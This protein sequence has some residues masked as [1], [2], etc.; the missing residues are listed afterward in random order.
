MSS[1]NDL[2]NNLVTLIQAG[3]DLA[4]SIQRDLEQDG[5]VSDESI[6]TLNSFYLIYE[7][8]EDILDIVN[9]IN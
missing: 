1:A 8:L 2:R 4:N 5:E 7:E 9:G 3:A 6:L